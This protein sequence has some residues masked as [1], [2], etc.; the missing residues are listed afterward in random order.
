MSRRLLSRSTLVAAC[1]L[2]VAVIAQ[3]Q[4]NKQN[5]QPRTEVN[6]PRTTA[7]EQNNRTAARQDG[8]PGQESNLDAQLAACV[9]IG[10]EKEI[11]ISRLVEQHSQNEQ[12]KQFAQQ[13]IQAHT[14]FVDQLAQ[15]AEQGG[16]QKQ[17]LALEGGEAQRDGAQPRQNR[18]PGTEERSTA[19]RP[20]KP[21]TTDGNAATRRSARSEV[22]DQSARSNDIISIEHEVA[23]QCLRSAEQEISQK[24]GAELDKCYTGM[25]VFAHQAMVDKLEVFSRHATGELQ[26]AL[27]QGIQTAQEHLQHAKQLHEQIASA[28]GAQPEQQKR[29]NQNS[30]PSPKPN[31]N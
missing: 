11:A 25:Q 1:G 23:Q 19:Q 22:L 31:Q 15:F 20:E 14:K 30:K 9:I 3:A 27:Q 24:Q 7:T 13:M 28:G 5:P 12:V 2:A 8:Q 10:N 18:Q 26:T 6:R 21:A 29:P 17:Q 4:E 16:Y